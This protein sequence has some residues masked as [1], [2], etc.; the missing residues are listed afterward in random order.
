MNAMTGNLLVSVECVR[1]MPRRFSWVDQELFRGGHMR[2]LRAGS[3]GLYLFLVTVGDSQGVSWY[4][5]GRLCEELGLS[6]SELEGCRRELLE[7]GLV[8]C[9]G[10]LWQVLALPQPRSVPAVR[11]SMEAAVRERE[12]EVAKSQVHR[13]LQER[14][15]SEEDAAQVE[16][17]KAKCR[18]MLAQMRGQGGGVG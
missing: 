15:W 7:R 3:L 16:A 18:Q 13:S 5:E 6:A 2:G 10:R 12:V 11:T 14:R 17:A 9:G 1:R 8:A 4:S